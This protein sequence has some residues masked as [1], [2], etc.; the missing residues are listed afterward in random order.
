MCAV[1]AALDAGS[2]IYDA[3]ST[4]FTANAARMHRLVVFS[5]GFPPEHPWLAMARAAGCECWGELDFAAVFWRGTI[6]AITGTNGKTT[7]TEFL[8]HAL[9]AAGRKAYAT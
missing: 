5:P 4:E 9:N 2:V 3:K 7:V 6:I 1:L 8:T